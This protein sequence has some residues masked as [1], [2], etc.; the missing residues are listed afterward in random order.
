[1][2]SRQVV[3]IVWLLAFAAC[4]GRADNPTGAAPAQE[5]GIG[6]K[7]AEAGMPVSEAEAGMP[8]P[9]A[10]MPVPEG[11]APAG[12]VLSCPEPVDPST[13][14]AENQLCDIPV[15]GNVNLCALSDVAAAIPQ[16]CGCT[17]DVVTRVACTGGY[18]LVTFSGV[19]SGGAF[20]Y[21]PDGGLIAILSAPFQDFDAGAGPSC[22]A[23]PATLPAPQCPAPGAGNL[24]FPDGG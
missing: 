11:G 22:A 13:C 4:G 1:M 9:E 18:T 24:C 16:V 10:G 23:G 6:E 14:S 7:P 12:D 17:D 20:Y 3:R 21:Q 5:A 8:V 2:Q 19:H 15:S